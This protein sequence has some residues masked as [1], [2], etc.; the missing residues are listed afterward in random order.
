MGTLSSELGPW[1]GQVANQPRVYADANLPNLVNAALYVIERRAL[2][3]YRALPAPRRDELPPG[4]AIVVVRDE[5]G[6][7]SAHVF[8]MPAP[9][10]EDDDTVRELKG[11]FRALFLA[12][13]F[14]VRLL[15]DY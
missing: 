2:E 1:V 8:D 12:K 14:N 11:F 6:N 3:P 7:E 9:D 15:V 5:E 10:E 4:S 13:G